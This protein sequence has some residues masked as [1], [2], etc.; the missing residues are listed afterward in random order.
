MKLFSLLTLLILFQSCK[1]LDYPQE[2]GKTTL[3]DLVQTEV[4]YK[5]DIQLPPRA[6]RAGY[7]WEYE[8]I[9]IYR[10]IIIQPR[11]GFITTEMYFPYDGKYVLTVLAEDPRGQIHTFS[12][13]YYSGKPASTYGRFIPQWIK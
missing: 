13:I 4:E 12:S 6:V 2:Y 11:T 10:S 7:Y 3:P 9:V 5:Y 8:G 1:S